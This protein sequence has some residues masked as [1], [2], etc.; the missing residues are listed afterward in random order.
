M[1]VQ[2]A[3]GGAFLSEPCAP[4]QMEAPLKRWKLLKYKHIIIRLA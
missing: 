1:Y 4:V 2:E 3:R